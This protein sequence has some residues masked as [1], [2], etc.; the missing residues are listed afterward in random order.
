MKVWKISGFILLLIWL[1][2]AAFIWFRTTDGAGIYQT[3]QIKE[4]TL[5]IWVIF[6]IPVFITYIIWGIILKRKK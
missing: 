3:I 1:V 6:A 2:V 4:V 5:L